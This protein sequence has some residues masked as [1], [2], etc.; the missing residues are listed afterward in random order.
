[1]NGS[2]WMKSLIPFLG[3]CQIALHFIAAHLPA[4]PSFAGSPCGCI[5]HRSQSLRPLSGV[6]HGL[7][8]VVALCHPREG[9]CP[10]PCDGLPGSAPRISFN[11]SPSYWELRTATKFCPPLSR[12]GR[13]L[14]RH[15]HPTHL[16]LAGL[17]R[18]A[19]T[20]HPE[21]GRFQIPSTNF[22][23]AMQA[24]NS[25]SQGEERV[26]LWILA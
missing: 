4:C 9:R 13:H 15:N 1:V 12:F 20:A 23:T 16:D 11:D 8:I 25:E 17:V 24:K 14:D 22:Q 2:S 26:R 21:A 10:F 19:G 3:V 5:A 18:Q 6:C 7:T